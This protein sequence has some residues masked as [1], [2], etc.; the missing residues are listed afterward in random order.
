MGKKSISR[1]TELINEKG[2]KTILPLHGVL[3]V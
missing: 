3:Q 1:S 2:S